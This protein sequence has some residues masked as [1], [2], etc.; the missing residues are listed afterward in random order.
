MS[1]NLTTGDISY[2]IKQLSFPSSIGFLFYT[3]FNVTDTYFASTISDNAIAALVLASTV[4]F[5]IISISRGMSNAVTSLVGNA[6]G[7]KDYIKV[8]NIV[9]HTYIF[10]LMMIVFLYI[11]YLLFV[12]YIF[13]FTNN[14]SDYL[15]NSMIFINII[16]LGLPFYLTS[17]YS[18][19]ILTSHGDTKSFRNIL[20]LNFFFNI[21]LNIWFIYGGLG[22][23]PLGFA[24]IA[25][26]TITTEFFASFYLFYKVY[27]LNLI[28]NFSFFKYNFNIIKEIFVQGLPSTMNMTL[29]SL[30]SFILIY[31]ISTISSDTVAA[32]GIG[33]RLE[34]MAL[35]PSIGISVAVAAM[36]AQNNGAKN[37]ERIELIMSKIYKYAFV[38]YAFGFVFMLLTGYLL[39]PFFTDSTFVLNETQTYIKVNA[40]LLLAYILIFVNVSFLQA[41]KKPNMIFYIGLVRQIILPLVFFYIIHY[42]NLSAIYYWFGTFISV[43]LATFYIHHLQKSYLKEL[44]DKA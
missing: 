23:P 9:V 35:I 4:Y 14:D 25:Y 36:I 24:G 17:S 44:N 39:A 22:L 1:K 21:I 32:Y 7:K 26:A 30:G 16:V 40:V 10:A 11:F 8:K 15:S 34:Q 28:D 3:L 13:Y 19:A 18:N 41:I 6:L 20:I 29:M 43:A 5:M 12:D 27:K 2:Q 37:F 42:F 33:I 31:F 38:L